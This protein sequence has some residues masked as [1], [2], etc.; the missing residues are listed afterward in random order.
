MVAASGPL[1]FKGRWRILGWV[2]LCVHVAVSSLLL[3]GGNSCKC[4]LE[5]SV[6]CSCGIACRA[7]SSPGESN[8]SA[9]HCRM[10]SCQPASRP[11]G[12]TKI[13]GMCRCRS[14]GAVPPIPPATMTHRFELALYRNDLD[15]SH[16]S[17]EG[18]LKPGHPIPPL[19]PP[20]TV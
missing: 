8:L 18:S 4:R 10:A 13:M 15:Q 17:D 16:L 14:S 19:K 6:P 11:S 9:P 1:L 20:P 7:H 2:A 5:Q 3:S 12:T